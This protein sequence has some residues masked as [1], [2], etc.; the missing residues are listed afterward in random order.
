MSRVDAV[1]APLLVLAGVVSVQFG[2]A[3]AA[4]LVPQIGAAGSVMLRLGF[5]TILLVAIA[6]PRW[7]GHS[8]RNLMTVACFGLALGLMNF[9]F[10]GALGHLP[11]GVAVTIEFIGPLSLAALLSRRPRD[12]LAVA[13]AAVGV[14]LISQALSIPL[15]QLEGT[16][17]LLALAAGACWAG[18]I[19][20]SGR[21]GAAF[22]R[23][24]GLALAMVFATVV[25]LPFGLWDVARHGTGAWTGE[26]LLKG[27]GI[28]VLSSVL[29]YSLE[30]FALRRLTPAVF[31]ILL[32]LEPAVAALAGLIVLGQ[33]LRP[34][35]LIGLGLVV[36]ASFLVLGLGARRTPPPDPVTS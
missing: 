8:R 3:L 33:S 9:A 2:G 18:Y 25:I 34:I 7:R 20:F 23:L 30:L 19:I 31:G 36:L 4:T 26:V 15:D 29:P 24:E 22:P 32:S 28:A 11:I 10:Y 35:Q 13:A 16:G 5:A 14:L 12:L 17:I 21:T 27:L 1:P 6:R